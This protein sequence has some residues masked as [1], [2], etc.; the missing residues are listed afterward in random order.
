MKFIHSDKDEE[1]Y[2]TKKKLIKPI[3]STVTYIDKTLTPTLITNTKS[4]NEN[5]HYSLDNI[6]INLYNGITLSFP[7]NLKHISFN[8]NNYHNVINLECLSENNSFQEEVILEK[9]RIS[10]CFNIFEKSNF[11]NIKPLY[12]ND[13]INNNF[14][15]NLNYFDINEYNKKKIIYL[16]NIEMYELLSNIMNN[17]VDYEVI[18]KFKEKCK[19]IGIYDT[20]EFKCF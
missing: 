19:T 11:Y 2:Q 5:N 6:D 3:L 8:G 18:D 9:Y 1:L 13:N 7:N 20:F 4:V 10:L 16:K 17:H 15:K 12:K 14:A